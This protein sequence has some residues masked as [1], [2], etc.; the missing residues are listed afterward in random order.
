MEYTYTPL[1][2]YIK[3][4]YQQT[5]NINEP[6]FIN[7]PEIAIQ[8]KIKLCYF[9]EQSTAMCR[10]GNY[11]IFLNELLSP[12]EQWQD[13]G[14]ELCHVLRHDGSQDKMGKPLLYLQE[15]QAN[16]F[17][18][19]FCVPTFML[20]NYQIANYFNILDG[21]PF[22][23]KN[24]NV[25]EEFARQRLIHF[26]NQIQQSKSDMEHRKYMESL[27]PKAP[28]Y[29]KETNAILKKLYMQL[30]KKGVKSNA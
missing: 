16:N 12:Q 13:F 11:R 28:P 29:S 18:L 15:N 27:Y 14:H 26:K 24:F 30:E 1:E 8:L 2:E 19:H 21:I 10:K 4:L 17:M 22:V 6:M 3:K 9:D 20:L 23:T 25:T 5:L 7:M